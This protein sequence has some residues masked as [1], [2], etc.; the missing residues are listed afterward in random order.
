[1]CSELLLSNAIRALS[2]DAI[3]MANSG[4]PGMPL[5]MADIAQVLWRK[6]FKH[7]PENPNWY[8]RDRFVLS[9]GHGSMLLYSLLH[10]TGYDLSIEDLKNFRQFGSKTPGH[11][12]KNV[13]PGV[14]ITTGPLGQ[15]LSNA[16]GMA[17]SENVLSKSFNREKIKLIDNYTWVF[18]GDGCLMEGISHEACSLAGHLKLNKLIVFYDSNNIS[19]DGNVK[20]WFTED[21]KKRF[22]SYNW[23]V[24][25]DVNGHDHIEINNAIKKAKSLLNKPVIIICKTLIGYGSPNKENSAE[26]H[27]SPLGEEEIKLTKKR[28]NWIYKPFFI[29]D[30]I[31]KK[32]NFVNKGRNLEKKWNNILLKYK[33]KYPKL[34]KEYIR[35]MEKKLPKKFS[36][37]FFNFIKKTSKY[38]N[39]I[40]T[41]QSSQNS[42]EVL[43]KYLPELLGG[44]ADL[45]PSNL[46]KWSGS[47]SIYN[48]SPGNYIDYGVREFGMT[49]IANGISNYGGFIPYTATFLMFMEYAK[50]AVRMAALMK[51]HHIFIYT[52]DSIGLGEDG[53][54]HQPIEQLSSLR[55]IPNLNVWR[56]CDQLETA[57][58]WKHSIER[59]DGPSALILSRQNLKFIKENKKNYRNI[60][61][62]G[63]ILKDFS[64]DP[65][66][67]IISCGSELSIAYEVSIILS[68]SNYNVRL[69]SMPSTNLFDSQDVSYK[70][71]VLPLKIENRVSIEAGT[72]DFWFK[73]IGYNNLSIGINKYADS[74]P[75][76]ILF[77]KFGFC[78]SKIVK[79]IKNFFIRKI[80]C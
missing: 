13:T 20:G 71:S 35:R 26:V 34:Y 60:C 61:M 11:P 6:H 47:K 68:K 73:Y 62:G 45:S 72:S 1:M 80:N 43:G 21:I 2:I 39:D 32:W 59:K 38:Y 31:Y 14:E 78:T 57:V 69:V 15:G 29:P 54:T 53:P 27:G 77:K 12:E 22:E 18:V 30:K 46:T 9:N 67:I 28:L 7:N 19:I 40:S 70:N 44:S 49:A 51:M 41:R 23:H 37:N 66:L 48:N 17:I 50:N 58:S 5:G 75:G 56:P 36:K 76:N 4:H 24:I 16:V 8:N 65:N 63:Y 64:D 79:K 52:H 25:E 3:Q 42:I 74:A 55:I 10:L 33:T